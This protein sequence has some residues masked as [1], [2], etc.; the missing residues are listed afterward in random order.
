MKK[1]YNIKTIKDL[2]IIPS[3]G[4]LIVSITNTCYLTKG[5]TYKVISGLANNGICNDNGGYNIDMSLF[6]K[7]SDYIHALRDYKLRKIGI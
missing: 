4:D 5:K 7:Y 3:E 1:K 2:G 6:V